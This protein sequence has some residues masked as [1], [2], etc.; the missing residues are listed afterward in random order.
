MEQSAR[1]QKMC[2]KF[3]TKLTIVHVKISR[4]NTENHIKKI[5]TSSSSGISSNWTSDELMIFHVIYYALNS[6]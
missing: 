1:D 5:E 3:M 2:G 6:Q 4:L